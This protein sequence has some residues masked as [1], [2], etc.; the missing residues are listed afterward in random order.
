MFVFLS[1]LCNRVMSNIITLICNNLKEKGVLSS[2]W[3]YQMLKTHAMI[4]ML[5]T[6]NMYL[7]RRITR[8][9]KRPMVKPG[10]SG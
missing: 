6:T 5:V 4:D 10:N 2:S 3:A 7:T 9:C 1:V 8:L